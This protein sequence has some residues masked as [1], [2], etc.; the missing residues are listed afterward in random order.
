MRST[1][2]FCVVIGVVGMIAAAA[3][4][5]APV[6][7]AV[8]AQPGF[9][10]FT[11][12]ITLPTNRDAQQRMNAAQDYIAEQEWA[13]AV[14]EIQ[15]LLNNPE[16]GFV[17]VSTDGPKPTTLWVSIRSEA[18]RLLGTMPR[19]GLKVYEDMFG[20][21]AATN[22]ERAQKQN[23]PQML[24]DVAQR[25]LHTKSGLK[26]A[27]LLGTR[28][29]ERDEAMMAAPYFERL[30]NG[31]RG[32]DLETPVILKAA[33]AFY[34]AGDKAG[35]D[36]EWKKLQARA[37]QDGGIQVGAQVVS[38]ERIR[39]EL[40][41]ASR[42]EPRLSRDVNYYRFTPSRTGQGTG[43]PISGDHVWAVSTVLAPESGSG[44]ARS[45]A[46]DMINNG[47][48][49][50]EQKGTPPL[51]A[52]QPIAV[53]GQVI[54]R[55][56]NGVYAAYLKEV[57]IE[58]TVG[59]EKI[60]EKKK[61]GD[62]A[63][64]SHTDGGILSLVRDPNK[65]GV[66][67][68]WR[69]QY[70]QW[71]TSNSVFENSITGTI[72]TDGS[73]VFA[74]D[75]LV[76]QPHPQALMQFRMGWGG[77]M[78]FGALQKQVA[79]RN[80]LKA[81]SIELGGSLRWELGGEHDPHEEKLPGKPGTRDSFFLG[82]PLPLADKLY[83]L[84]EKDGALR[85]IC[86]QPKDGAEKNPPAPDIVWVQTL[87]NA[88][89]KVNLDFNRRMHAAHLAY[90]DGILVCPTNA[91][92]VLG[93]DLL[94]HSL[95]WA[96]QYREPEVVDP[97]KPAVRPQIGFNPNQQQMQ[98]LV[99]EWKATAP[100]V[101]DGK[102]VFAAPDS[103]TIHC[104][105]LR[106]GREVWR[107]KREA[108][109]LYFAG[110]FGGKVLIVGKNQVRALKLTTGEDVWKLGNTGTPSGQGVASDNVYYLPIRA[111]ADPGKEPGVLAINLAKGEL[112]G[113][114]KSAKK[115]GRVEIPGN[116][117]FYDGY[118]LSQGLNSLVCYPVLP[119]ED[120]P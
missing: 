25:F 100:A 103:Q 117:I 22:L 26:A 52:F 101:V 47:S 70:N 1:R 43:G 89:D 111:S 49:Q 116:L 65:K 15:R 118:L 39:E 84:N 59:G 63:W 88:K 17:Q 12:P 6:D 78:N 45:W 87:A 7:V 11:S 60:R 13:K 14:K 44:D 28:C 66:I 32:A 20:R 97:K 30:V 94:T 77:Q 56:Y 115:D 109:D 5:L 55:T 64:W 27:E 38:I 29:L 91:G 41:K 81:F 95:V 23:D 99:N 40:D 50:V 9:D 83:V 71:G 85:I 31:P 75:D 24:A 86:L 113:L 36:E 112:I 48:R 58:I 18:N 80:T 10:P 90:G 110:V 107:K 3:F 35:G 67:D 106:D 79:D 2:R 34:R 53:P 93:V 68:S 74:I 108:D 120:N 102:V 37:K 92:T 98:Y 4:M 73:R 76:I 96:H 57:D 54:Y 114:T 21:E 72:S 119:K 105:S 8:S 42:E 19:D 46:E 33:L 69:A 104:L 16:D 62:H 51:P 82:P 61:P